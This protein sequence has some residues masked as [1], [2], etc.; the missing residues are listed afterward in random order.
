[1]EEK[2]ARLKTILA[3]AHDLLHVAEL[4]EWDQQTYM[5]VGGAEDRGYHIGTV[6]R[7]AHERLSSDG[8]GRLVEELKPYAA[9]LDPDSNEARLI[10]V[11]EREYTKRTRV[12]PE[13]VAELAQLQALGH[14]AWTEAR[15]EDNFPKFR[16][17][18]EKIVDQRRRYAEYFAPY[19]HVY[20]PLL[21]EYEPGMKTADVKQI[22]TALRPKQVELIQAIM[23]RPQ[24]DDSVLHQPYEEQKQWDFGL[25]VVQ[26]FG[27]DM[28][29]GR[30]DKAPHPFTSSYGLGD[31]RITT[32]IMPNYL[33]SALFSTMHE[34]GHAMYEQ[35]IDPAMARTTLG[36]TK[37]LTLHESQ[38]RLWE[39]LVGRS[40]PFWQHFYPQLQATF[41]GQLGGADLETFYRAIN[42]VEPSLIRTESDEATYN[43][44]IMLRLELEIA[45][46]EGNLAVKDLPE[47]WNTRMQE[48]L[49]VIPPNDALGVL[50]DVHWSHG[51]IGYFSTYALGNLV[52][53]QLWERL[54]T[55]LPDLDEQIRRG[56]FSALLG[57]L[58]EKIHRHGAKFDA[59]ELVQRVT[60]SKIDPAPYLRYLTQKYRGIYGF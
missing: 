8:L 19:D 27:Y 48:Y 23:S 9:Q 16:P 29:R 32:R 3:E 53:G 57:W 39:N 52:A 41:P 14:R 59:Q 15:A 47:A 12:P 7:L 60:G 54:R 46:M 31:V 6:K 11:T 30:Q 28:R 58:R 5:P 21:F 35:G 55:D 40:R 25:R 42:K 24:V 17:L 43:L 34:S 44:H 38:S 36:E 13:M 56:E 37:S 4:L 45:L 10:R 26:K 22:F 2:L 18:L 50:Q 33:A 1:M 51:N 49:G 20:D